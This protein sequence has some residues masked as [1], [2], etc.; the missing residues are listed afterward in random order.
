[1]VVY[2][3]RTEIRRERDRWRIYFNYHEQAHWTRTALPL[4]VDTLPIV[5]IRASE[6]FSRVSCT[7]NGFQCFSD[8]SIR[9]LGYYGYKKRYILKIYLVFSSWKLWCD[10]IQLCCG[11]LNVV[12]LINRCYVGRKELGEG[13]QVA[14]RKWRRLRRWEW[15]LGGESVREVAETKRRGEC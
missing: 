13:A 14:S 9:N 8:V 1:M 10:I 11:S 15:N 5:I 12:V 7:N 3:C 4:V 2:L 6:H